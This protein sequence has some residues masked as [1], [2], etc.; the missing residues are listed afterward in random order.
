MRFSAIHKAASYLMALF[1][2]GALALSGE[3]RVDVLL[4]TTALIGVSWFFEPP[5]AKPERWVIVWNVAALLA[6]GYTLLTAFTKGELVISGG[7]LLCVLLVAKLF[8][9]R[10]SRDYQW[11]YVISFL[12]LAAA[13]TLN[14][15]ISFALCFLGYVVSATWA[16]ILFHLRREMEDNFLLKHSDDSSSER[17]EVDRILNSRRVVGKGFLAVTAGVSLAIFVMASAMFVLFPRVG[18]GMFFQKTRAKISFAGFSDGVSLGGH[19]LIRNDDTVV[20]RVTVS[21]PAYRGTDV[22]ELH[23][24]GVAFD[25][26]SGGKW[27]RGNAQPVRIRS[28]PRDRATRFVLPEAQRESRAGWEQKALVQ[29]IYLEPLDT[30]TLFGASVPLAYE[31]SNVS[32][33]QRGR[34]SVAQND[35]IRFDHTQG[36]RYVVLSDPALPP[37][38]LLRAV[39]DVD[40]A[41]WQPYLEIPAE[42]PPRVLALALEITAGKAGPYAKAEAVKKYLASYG[43][44]LQQET[45][46]SFEPLDHFLFERKRGHCEYF[47]S[48]MAILLR[49]A[50]VPTRNVNGF[51]GGEWN[52]SGYIA[53]RGGD[54]HSW[55]EVYFDGYGWL[56][57]D[58]TP[59]ATGGT[60][61]R[62]GGDFFDR[63][64]RM[65]DNARFSW[66]KWVLEYD[67]AR[68]LD[69]MKSIAESLRSG[70]SWNTKAISAWVREHRP[71]LAS[72][73]GGLVLAYALWRL[74]KRPRRGRRGESCSRMTTDDHTVVALWART[75]RLLGK[76][77]H[78]RP[79]AQTPREHARRLAAANAPGSQPYAALTE[80]YYT[81]R[82][83]VDPEQIGA[84]D[85]ETAARLAAEVKRELT[86]APRP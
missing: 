39:P 70:P 24:R 25:R 80:L 5:R 66:F 68:Q 37:A 62:G 50:G 61:A 49:A 23:W 76:H 56:T 85:A 36:L 44:T 78:R 45:D 81:V 21:D 84:V 54:A 28:Q 7:N 1:G 33:W 12:M 58:P 2:F 79:P 8:T 82:Y 55:V 34:G 26:Y 6:F 67:L 65:L 43:Y 57:Y 38:A 47:S 27:S 63:L 18:F 64:R 46:E 3:L 13:T 60:M 59:A 74:V 15:D 48:A 4:V 11:V 14:A 86:A 22:P 9:R 77:G 83:S 19:G 31:L 69:V 17:V 30:P 71:W 16:L 51:L 52:E 35:E 40:P 42:I 10:S 75:E 29:E 72:G 41:Q 53:V 20:M 73:F 32:P